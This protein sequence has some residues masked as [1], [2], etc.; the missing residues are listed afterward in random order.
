[1]ALAVIALLFTG[2]TGNG[3]YDWHRLIGEVVLG[4]LVFRLCWG[5]VGS[6][7][8]RL[9]A[10][11]SNPLSALSHL[12]AFARREPDHERGHNPAGAW[13]ALILLLL[14]AVQAVTGLFIAD[15]DELVEGAFY[16][17]VNSS[18]AEWLLHVHHTNAMFIQIAVAIHV[19]MV[20]AYL[21]Y[22]KQNLI[23]AMITGRKRFS[24]DVTLPSLKVGSTVLGA[25]IAL[26]S[27][28]AMA[29]LFNWF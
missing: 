8:V 6:S 13:A 12:R 23:A 25:V 17:S 11:V 19:V 5:V 15:E 7:N 27:F 1:M 2:E 20:F 16:A 14:L 28:A 24:N 26:V 9:S 10:L 4:L 21:L 29:L 22:A 3:F 18:T